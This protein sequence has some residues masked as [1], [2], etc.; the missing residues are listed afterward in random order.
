MRVGAEE[1][2]KAQVNSATTQS[3]S[4]MKPVTAIAKRP[5]T[6]TVANP[7]HAL[8]GNFIKISD[9]GENELRNY[10]EDL[11]KPKAFLSD[12]INTNIVAT[13]NR[14]FGKAHSAAKEIL[15]SRAR[16]EEKFPRAKS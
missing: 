10:Y 11:P 14:A 13:S 8:Q 7:A 15:R 3:S 6:P 5:I 1:R 4:S 12:Q 2:A 16:A 9:D